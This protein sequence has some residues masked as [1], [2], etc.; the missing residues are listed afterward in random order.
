MPRFSHFLIFRQTG[1]RQNY[2]RHVAVT[3][4]L[5]VSRRELFPVY[6]DS[7]CLKCVLILMKLVKW[8]TFCQ[9]LKAKCPLDNQSHLAA[10][11]VTLWWWPDLLMIWKSFKSFW[12]KSFCGCDCYLSKQENTKLTRGQIFL[13]IPLLFVD[14]SSFHKPETRKWSQ[15]KYPGYWFSIS[16]LTVVVKGDI[17][18]R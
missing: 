9:L 7:I 1:G 15:V 16:R 3:T 12:F 17:I 11:P 8:K 6:S 10:K 2:F 13:K 14:I 18:P 5:H 4:K